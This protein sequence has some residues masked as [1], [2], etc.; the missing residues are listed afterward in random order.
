MHV[1]EPHSHRGGAHAVYEVDRDASPPVRNLIAVFPTA[2]SAIDAFPD[3]LV[4]T[5]STAL[6]HQQA[7]LAFMEKRGVAAGRDDGP[8]E[9]IIDDLDK[10]A[11]SNPPTGDLEL[12]PRTPKASQRQKFL[13][14]PKRGD[15]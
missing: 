9:P 12:L 1:V 11:P 5:V 4:K 7:M 14:R 13:K 8:V 2:E 6:D 15:D 3:A 10:G